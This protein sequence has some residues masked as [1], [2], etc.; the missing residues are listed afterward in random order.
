MTKDNE[1]CFG[2]QHM[3]LTHTDAKWSPKHTNSKCL[4]K[5]T[6][7]VRGKD[8]SQGESQSVE[9]VRSEMIIG[10]GYIFGLNPVW[11]DDVL[12]Q[13]IPRMFAEVPGTPN[14]VS[15][16]TIS[17]NTVKFY[18]FLRLHSLITH[19]TESSSTAEKEGEKKKLN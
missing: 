17:A 7:N 10:H 14:S 1:G 2:H 9:T 16:V 19:I 4:A 18:V 3:E 13:Q 8:G 11:N 6:N 15:S 12:K 5:C